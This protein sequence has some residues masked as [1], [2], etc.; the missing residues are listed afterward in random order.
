MQNAFNV[1]PRYRLTL[2]PVSV[3]LVF[4]QSTEDNLN[5]FDVTLVCSVV[6]ARHVFSAL[7]LNDLSVPICRMQLFHSYSTKC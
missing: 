2:P 6:D 5:T 4:V 7:N 1:G 3:S